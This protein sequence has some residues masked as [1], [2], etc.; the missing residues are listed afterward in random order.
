LVDLFDAAKTKAIYI[1]SHAQ[2]NPIWPQI[3]GVYES[4]SLTEGRPRKP[5]FIFISTLGTTREVKRVSEHDVN[6][7]MG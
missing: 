7:G 1:Q 3:C 5:N 2:P 4:G 6:Q